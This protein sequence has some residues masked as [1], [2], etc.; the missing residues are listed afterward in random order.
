M[1]YSILMQWV[2]VGAAVLAAN[3]P[4][5]S[6]AGQRFLLFFAVQKKSIWMHLLEMLLLYALLGFVAFAIERSAGQVAAQGWEF[7][8]VTAA[9]FLTLAFP[10]FTYRYLL[11]KT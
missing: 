9:L 2:L 3:L 6:F 8:A 11:R 1:D 10:G 4:F 7:Y 5:L